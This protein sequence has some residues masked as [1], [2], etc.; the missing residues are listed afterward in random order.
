MAK[1][2]GL[3]SQE[4]MAKLAEMG[5]PADSHLSTVD[6]A[7]VARL[8]RDNGR[9]PLASLG[10]MGGSRSESELSEPRRTPPDTDSGI[11]PE[12]NGR[13]A[14]LEETELQPATPRE[15][16]GHKHGI[17][18]QL[19]ELP[20]L[21]AIAFAI[22][23]V[24]KIFLVQ[25][26]FIPSGSMRPTLKV[27][28]RVLVEKLSYRFGGPEP[29]QVV[30]FE[31]S[32]FVGGGSPDLP[33]TEDVG[34]FVSELLGLPT[35]AKED[36]IKRVVAL[37]GDS[38]RYQGS[39]RELVVNGQRVGQPYIQGGVDRSSG[40]ITPKNCGAMGLEPQ[41][42]GCRVPAGTVFVM[43]DNRNNSQDSRFFGPI[44][45]EDLVGRAFFIIWPLGDAGG[46]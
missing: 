36:F 8:R 19:L 30:V 20:I 11:W 22:A 42:N 21:I 31:R 7:S 25:A 37:G 1:E 13:G 27:G 3:T 29:G 39:P 10:E 40:T 44:K 17:G 35:G 5:A 46:V 34:N 14:A 16:N 45:E 2:L 12:E 38:I 4:V 32:A 26:F 43:G 28:D 41:P 23:V 18:H 6:A 15:S 9:G 33:W 24:I